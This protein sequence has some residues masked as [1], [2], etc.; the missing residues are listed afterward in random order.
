VFFVGG[1]WNAPDACVNG[2]AFRQDEREGQDALRVGF[3]FFWLACAP[4]F[5]LL[6]P[7]S[8]LSFNHFGFGQLQ[9]AWGGLH[10]DLQFC[11]LGGCLRGF[12]V[13]FFANGFWNT[14]DACVNGGAFRQ[15]ER[16]GQDA[17]RV[18]FIF[19]WLACA[20]FFE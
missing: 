12:G 2:G 17:L 11:V 8:D 3:I 15:D 7:V 20:L 18:G 1:F 9:R 5:D 19:F 13:Y 14:P 10:I 4:F 6:K 16:E